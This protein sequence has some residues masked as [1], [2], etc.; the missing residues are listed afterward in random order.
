MT[1]RPFSPLRSATLP[2]RPKGSF[3]QDVDIRP[4]VV[5]PHVDAS[6]ALLSLSA[7]LGERRAYPP[8]QVVDLLFIDDERR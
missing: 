8:E 5:T 1:S 7:D 2:W 3:A 4:E 6:G